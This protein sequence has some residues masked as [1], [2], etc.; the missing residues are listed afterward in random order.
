MA[1]ALLPKHGLAKITTADL[2]MPASMFAPAV[3]TALDLSLE[4]SK[5]QLA[6]GNVMHADSVPQFGQVH[7][8][9]MR[10]PSRSD[11]AFFGN[12]IQFTPK[13]AI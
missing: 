9:A 11:Q 3:E 10:T 8:K 2:N 7:G 6:T 12:A 13:S 4:T 1:L 5:S